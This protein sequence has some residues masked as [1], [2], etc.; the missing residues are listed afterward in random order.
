MPDFAVRAEYDYQPH[1]A[2]NPILLSRLGVFGLL[3]IN[4][5]R[6][7]HAFGARL[8]ALRSLVNVESKFQI[9]PHADRFAVMDSRFESYFFRRNYG[10][11]GQ[12]EWKSVN[13]PDVPDGAFFSENYAERDSPSNPRLTRLICVNGFF[14]V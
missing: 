1:I 14:S 6:L 3:H 11:V 9:A 7:A 8:Q 5:L 2:F 10:L 12:A 13:H 4:Q